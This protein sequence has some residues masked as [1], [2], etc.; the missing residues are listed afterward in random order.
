MK[1]LLLLLLLIAPVA[2]AEDTG[3]SSSGN[4]E[5]F[6]ERPPEYSDDQTDRVYQGDPY[7]GTRYDTGQNPQNRPNR[8]NSGTHEWGMRQRAGY[9]KTTA[10]GQ[11]TIRMMGSDERP[12]LSGSQAS[13][14]LIF[15]RQGSGNGGVPNFD[16][17]YISPGDGIWPDSSGGPYSGNPVTSQ[18][19]VTQ[20]CG[21]RSVIVNGQC[22][23][24]P[25]PS[26]PPNE[27]Y[28]CEAGTY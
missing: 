16:I 9:D 17:T 7:A 10:G 26:N 21:G 6:E 27:T 1:K 24:C 12:N 4:G 28:R 5:E 3:G 11:R 8:S 18:N 15:M 13:S 14:P 19:C 22:A 23:G 2:Y 25:D 20:C